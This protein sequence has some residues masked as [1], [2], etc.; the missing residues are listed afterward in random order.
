MEEL[1]KPINFS[2]NVDVELIGKKSNVSIGQRKSDPRTLE[3]REMCH[4]L[5][6]GVALLIRADINSPE[7]MKDAIEHLNSEFGSVESFSDAK[8]LNEEWIKKHKK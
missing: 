7:L 5:I 1:K 8:I 3:L 2:I 4:M 6:S